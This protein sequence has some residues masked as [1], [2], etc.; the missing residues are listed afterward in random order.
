LAK[1]ARN[2]RVDIRQGLHK[3]VV[4]CRNP[5]LWRMTIRLP[6]CFT[7]WV[8]ISADIKLRNRP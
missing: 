6:K 8:K 4:F 1:P 7:L 5:L 3:G 2:N